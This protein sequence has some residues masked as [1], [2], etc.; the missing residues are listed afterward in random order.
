MINFHNK[1]AF[2]GLYFAILALPLF[3][4]CRDANVLLEIKSESL[5]KSQSLRIVLTRHQM[6][7][8][9][10]LLITQV[11]WKR[12][13]IR[14]LDTL[15]KVQYNAQFSDFSKGMSQIGQYRAEA[16]A[17]RIAE[18]RNASLL[19]AVSDPGASAQNA[20]GIPVLHA[21]PA[22]EKFAPIDYPTRLIRERRP[23]KKTFTVASA[24]STPSKHRTEG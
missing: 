7:I 1:H 12:K 6:E 23:E 8:R 24:T 11:D 14:L 17:K 9:E 20:E 3:S 4:G 22:L 19:I 13:Q 10:A 18:E 16:E 5:K 21:D 2:Y 15:Q